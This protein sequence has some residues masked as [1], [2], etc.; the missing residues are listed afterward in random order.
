MPDVETLRKKV[1]EKTH[2]ETGGKY[3]CDKCGRE[4]DTVSVY[5]MRWICLQCEREMNNV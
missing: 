5:G 2:K 1:D 3:I 4:V